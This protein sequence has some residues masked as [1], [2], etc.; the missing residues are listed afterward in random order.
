MWAIIFRQVAR[1]GFT[2]AVD[3]GDVARRDTLM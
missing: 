1:A 2:Q 3:T